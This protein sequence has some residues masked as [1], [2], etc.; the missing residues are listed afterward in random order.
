MKISFSRVVQC[1]TAMLLLSMACVAQKT[2]SRSSL[3]DCSP[4]A[5]QILRCPRVGFTYKVPF[6]WVDRTKEVQQ[7]APAPSKSPQAPDETAGEETGR[8]LL[9]V[10]ERPPGTSGESANSAVIIAVEY[11]AAYPQVKTAADYFGPLADVAEQRGLKMDGDPYS[12]S[13]GSK[14]VV[15]GDFNGD[16]KKTP[17]RQTSLVLLDDGY[18]LSFT[19]LASSDDEIDS[20]IENLTFTS[21]Q[22][23][24]SPK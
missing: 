8:T 7:S 23:K 17:L 11:R 13:I 9:A 19:F 24:A 21:N 14:Q 18:L 5:G 20:L 3:P 1:A 4:L 16:D 10:F 2:A 12:F 6:G 22:R 15:R